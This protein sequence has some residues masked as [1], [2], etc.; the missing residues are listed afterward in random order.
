MFWIKTMDNFSGFQNLI[1][2]L[3]I[4]TRISRDVNST[5]VELS[6]Q[7]QEN[8]DSSQGVVTTVVSNPED[9]NSCPPLTEDSEIV[10][11]NL[12]PVVV[13]RWRIRNYEKQ[14]DLVDLFGEILEDK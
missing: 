10:A 6:T 14:Y 9:G 12:R 2:A 3:L 8:F 11:N 1:Q 5:I 4:Q 13:T 7:L